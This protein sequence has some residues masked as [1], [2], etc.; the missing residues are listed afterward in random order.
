MRKFYRK[1]SFFQKGTGCNFKVLMI[2]VV[3]WAV[4][5]VVIPFV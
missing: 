2:A 5:E 3:V 4:Y 1:L